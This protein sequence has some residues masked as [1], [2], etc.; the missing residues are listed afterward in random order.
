MKDIKNDEDIFE[1][2]KRSNIVERREIF[3][4]LEDYKNSSSNFV[5][6]NFPIPIFFLLLTIF[7]INMVTIIISS[8]LTIITSYF[9]IKEVLEI[10]KVVSVISKLT[11]F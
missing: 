6:K 8:L 5:K 1:F 11:K 10:L 2:F 7:Y 9:I 3:N 4:E